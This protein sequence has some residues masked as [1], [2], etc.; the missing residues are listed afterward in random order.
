M[1][2]IALSIAGNKKNNPFLTRQVNRSLKDNWDASILY[3]IK[4]RDLIFGDS[5]SWKP[6]INVPLPCPLAHEVCS[7]PGV[8]VR[9]KFQG[10]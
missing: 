5:P 4:G 2:R 3:K 1:D 10:W 7:L 8:R 6:K 9:D